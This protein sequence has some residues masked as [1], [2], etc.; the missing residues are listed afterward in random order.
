MTQH[1]PDDL[2]DTDGENRAVRMFL[3]IYGTSSLTIQAMK[4]HLEY[5]GYPYWPEWADK[6][7]DSDT[8]HLTKL[9]AQNWIRHLFALEPEAIRALACVNA[10]HDMD[11]EEIDEIRAWAHGA[12]IGM[13]LA[14]K[15][16]AIGEYQLLVSDLQTTVDGLIE[17]NLYQAKLLQAQQKMLL[18]AGVECGSKEMIAGIKEVERIEQQIEELALK[19]YATGSKCRKALDQRDEYKALLDEY[20]PES[21]L[22]TYEDRERFR[23]AIAKAGDK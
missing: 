1:T 22:Q 2:L 18:D 17:G 4:Q 23:K 10:L 21:R 3:A 19:L 7:Q 6:Y 8:T 11:N 13:A 9:G 15:D 20:K 16:K 12:G 14:M 5:C